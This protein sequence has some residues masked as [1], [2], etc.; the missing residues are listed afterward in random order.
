MIRFNR[1][2]DYKH[3]EFDTY[4]RLHPVETRTRWGVVVLASVLSFLL[5]MYLT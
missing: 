3:R 2:S 5:G 4:E 1:R